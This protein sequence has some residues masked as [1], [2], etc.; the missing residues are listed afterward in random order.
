MTLSTETMISGKGYQA[1]TATLALKASGSWC[2]DLVVRQ[3]TNPAPHKD[4]VA[5]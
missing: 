3:E 1:F 2:G 4:R 5:R